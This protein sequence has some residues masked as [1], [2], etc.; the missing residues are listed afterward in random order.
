MSKAAPCTGSN[1]ALES[2]M[3][4]D[5]AKPEAARDLRR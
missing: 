3:F 5:G 4:A 1:M 2:P